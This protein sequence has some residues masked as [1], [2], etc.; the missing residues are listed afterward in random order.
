[1]SLVE[2]LVLRPPQYQRA[3]VSGLSGCLRAVLG[4]RYQP[5][6][7]LSVVDRND[8]PNANAP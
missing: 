3:T 6:S 1:M 7:S 8:P 5:G 2:V 4:A